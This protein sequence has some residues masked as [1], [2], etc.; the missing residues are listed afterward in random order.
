MRHVRPYWDNHRH[1][2]AAPIDDIFRAAMTDGSI[3]LHR[4]RVTGYE[5]SA[6]G[7]VTATLRGCGLPPR[8]LE[9]DRI[10][11]CTG[12]EPDLQKLDVPLLRQLFAEG[13]VQTNPVGFGLATNAS[14]ALIDATGQASPALFTIGPPMK[15]RLW[16]TTAVPELRM[17][18][19][20]LAATLLKQLERLP[21]P[22]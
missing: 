2:T 1:R 21:A 14:G 13:R 10:V 4:A 8:Q 3:L 7:G 20:A 18:A 16:E 19:M 11:Y 15:G 22:H 17:Q 12:P 9:V 5:V 6:T